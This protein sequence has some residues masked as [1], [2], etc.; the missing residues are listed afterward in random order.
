MKIHATTTLI[1]ADGGMFMRRKRA[2]PRGRFFGTWLLT[3]G[4]FHRDLTVESTPR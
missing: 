3:A 1:P 4:G 2:E